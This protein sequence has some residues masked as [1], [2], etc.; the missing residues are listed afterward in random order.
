MITKSGINRSKFKIAL[1][2]NVMCFLRDFFLLKPTMRN[3]GASHSH[4]DFAL[5]SL[6]HQ[7]RKNFGKKSIQSSSSNLRTITTAIYKRFSC[8]SFL[9]NIG[10]SSFFTNPV[11]EGFL[12]IRNLDIGVIV[13]KI[14]GSFGS[15]E[16]NEKTAFSINNSCKVSE[17]CI[18]H[19]TSL[20]MTKQ[21]A[22]NPNIC[23]A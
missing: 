16:T 12:V 13:E 11:Y 10:R 19:N 4:H 17:F 18:S 2:A 5:S 14:F 9:L 8:R 21:Y 7:V 22:I 23:T 20:L 3:E 6:N 15:K 1:I